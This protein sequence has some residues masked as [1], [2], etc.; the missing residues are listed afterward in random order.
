MEP[1]YLVTYRRGSGSVNTHQYDYLLDLGEFLIEA[2][3]DEDINNIVVTTVYI[4]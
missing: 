3:K 2:H 4:P 1:I